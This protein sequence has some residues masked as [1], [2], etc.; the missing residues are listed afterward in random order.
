MG[1]PGTRG[2]GRFLGDLGSKW[3]DLVAGVEVGV[4]GG[5]EDEGRSK[6]HTGRAVRTGYDRPVCTGARVHGGPMAR[7]HGVLEE[8][9]NCSGSVGKLDFEVK[10]EGWKV[11]EGARGVDLLAKHRIHG[12]NPTKSHQTNKSQKKLGLFLVG[13]F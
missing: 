10:F 9:M 1:S 7:V 4:G 5:M 2:F 3:M 11:G 12:P 6:E 13:N 8:R